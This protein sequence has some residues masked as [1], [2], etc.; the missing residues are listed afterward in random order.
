M[1][2]TH[3][4]PILVY[5]G[6]TNIVLDERLVQRAMRLTGARTKR[7]TVDLALRELVE[8]REVLGRLRALRGRLMPA[9]PPSTE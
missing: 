8:K 4:L 7:Q 9:Q 1:T 3:S 2:H 6:R 5:M